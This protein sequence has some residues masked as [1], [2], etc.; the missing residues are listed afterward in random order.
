MAGSGGEALVCNPHDRPLCLLHLGL[1]AG[2]PG[3]R[4]L[5]R[6]YVVVAPA[7]SPRPL[8]RARERGANRPV[9]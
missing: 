4:V 8:S 3:C 5:A 9:C 7:L 1:T 2:L 6:R